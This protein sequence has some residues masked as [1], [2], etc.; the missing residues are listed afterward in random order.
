MP[1]LL[2]PVES[3]QSFPAHSL[4]HKHHFL[5]TFLRILWGSFL[6]FNICYHIHTTPAHRLGKREYPI[7]VSFVISLLPHIAF[8]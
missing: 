2:S 1:R 7:I 8:S 6:Y 3:S 5:F 4:H